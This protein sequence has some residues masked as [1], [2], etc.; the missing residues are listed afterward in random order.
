MREE[1]WKQNQTEKSKMSE[2]KKREGPE[3][4]YP[5]KYCDSKTQSNAEN[6]NLEA[7]PVSWRLEH[8]G[9]EA[10]SF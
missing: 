7:R 3:Q 5:R 10:E 1:Y 2:D 9:L 4:A 6:T 8:T